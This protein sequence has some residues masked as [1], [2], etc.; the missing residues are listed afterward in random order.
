[1]N[2][3][4]QSS[5]RM[6]WLVSEDGQLSVSYAKDEFK[7]GVKFISKLV[8][9]GLYDP[10]SFTQNQQTYRTFVKQVDHV[11]GVMVE[12]TLNQVE[13]TTKN[14][15]LLLSTL[16]GPDGTSSV[17][18]KADVPANRAYI[19]ADCEHPEV[20]FRILDLMCREDFTITSR[21]GK[22]GENWDYV[23][24]LNEEEI[25]KQASEAAG[26]TVEYD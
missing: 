8:E 17:A 11:V 26:S 1:M 2:S 13:Q 25:E 6:N 24:N 14:N 20:A 9:E 4:T 16:D 19:T 21:W 15:W 18:Y 22:Q 7:E 5:S 12:M 23:T 3:F 10:V